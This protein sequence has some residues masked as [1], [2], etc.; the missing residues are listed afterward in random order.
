MKAL[1]LS[2]TR[3]A[4]LMSVADPVGGEQD[5]LV[6]V[7]AC[8]VCGS[9][10]NAWAGVPG[11]N[12]PLGPGAPGHEVWGEVVSGPSEFWAGQAVTGLFSCGYAEYAVAPLPQVIAVP[13]GLSGHVLLG[14][15]LACA[16]GVVQ[17]AGI[18]ERDSVAVVGFG[19]LAALIMSLQRPAP[20]RW[21]ALT[22]RPSA[23]ELALAL[24]AE[25]VCDY[26]EIPGEAWD[27]FDVVVEAAGAQQALD[28]ATWLTRER[29]RL[30]IAGY[31]ADGPRA[32]NMQSWN[33]KGLDVIN[34]HERDPRVYMRNL[35]LAL[36]VVERERLEVQRFITHEWPLSRAGE[37][38]TAAERHPEGYIKGVVRPWA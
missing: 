9:D 4:S 32:V 23:R 38:L 15:P 26:G 36:D 33:W 1:V 31:H 8:G 14:E 2:G 21:L 28:H 11:V 24:G 22:R 13:S 5:V 12:F 25:A 10:L 19:Y 34:A 3:T 37:A 16:M 30:V 35:G 18:R 20:R 7:L 17:R 27:S 6:R 29:G